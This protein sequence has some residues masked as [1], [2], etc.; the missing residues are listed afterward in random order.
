MEIPFKVGQILSHSLNNAEKAPNATNR[1][2]KIP[3]TQQQDNNGNLKIIIKY[4]IIGK[5]KAA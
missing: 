1:M 3:K 4:Q 2:K 5:R